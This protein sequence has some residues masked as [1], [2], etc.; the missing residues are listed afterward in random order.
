MKIMKCGRQVKDEYEGVEGTA[1]KIYGIL[2][3]E[4][5]R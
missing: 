4:L 2:F 5:F 1:W 3:L